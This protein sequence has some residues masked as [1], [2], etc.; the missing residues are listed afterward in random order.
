MGKNKYDR[1]KSL[2]YDQINFFG[3]DKLYK[4]AKQHKINIT[5]ETTECMLVPALA[6]IACTI[7]PLEKMIAL[8]WLSA[9]PFPRIG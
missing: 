3:R 2:Y 5:R 4:L 7:V 9:L 8:F 1:L 6:S